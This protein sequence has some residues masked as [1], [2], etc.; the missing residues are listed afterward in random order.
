MKTMTLAT[1]ALLAMS[2]LALAG[3]DE[4]AVTI[5]LSNASKDVHTYHIKCQYGGKDPTS[6]GTP[7]V[8]E[9]TNGVRGLQTSTSMTGIKPDTRLMS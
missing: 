6:C 9:N 2:G 7:S 3:E 1:A 8:W 4:S 5:D